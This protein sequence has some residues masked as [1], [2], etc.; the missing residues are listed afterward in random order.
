MKNSGSLKLIKDKSLVEE[1]TASE[2]EADMAEFRAFDQE[3]SQWKAF[4]EFIDNNFPG[5][6]ML[7]WLSRPQNEKISNVNPE[8]PKIKEKITP[9]LM[10]K[11]KKLILTQDFKRKFGNYLFQKQGLAKLS[12]ANY[13]RVKSK[14]A[15]LLSHINSYLEN[16]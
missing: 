16:Q 6:L 5:E 2:V 3:T 4:F 14:T 8:F 10:E 11:N 13:L 12:F 9:E 1:I 15:P 7:L